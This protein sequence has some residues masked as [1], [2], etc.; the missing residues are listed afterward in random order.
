MK[1]ST[2]VSPVPGDLVELL[3]PAGD[4]P[5]G[6]TAHVIAVPHAGFCVVEGADG[7]PFTVATVA[8]KITPW[9][10]LSG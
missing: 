7:R 9:A 1:G 4:S 6:T 8:L 3:V 10:S 5:A 2:R